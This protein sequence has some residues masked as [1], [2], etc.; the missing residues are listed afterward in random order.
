MTSNSSIPPITVDFF[1]IGAGKSGST[2][3]AQCLDEHPQ[4]TIARSKEPNFFV[5]K[6]SAF[7]G[8]S[9]REFMKDWAWYTDQY[10]HTR[11]GDRLGDFS[12]NLMHNVEDAPKLIHGLYP[13]AK[14]ITILR[15]PVQRTYSHYW[16]EKDHDR[17][18]G[19][20]NHFEDALDN[21]ELLFRSQYGTQLEAWRA[22]VPQE[23]FF[24]ILDFE[25]VKD[26][27]GVMRRLLRFLGVDDTF[28]PPSLVSRVN[29]SSRVSGTLGPLRKIAKMARS[30]GLGH[31]LDM[32]GRFGLQ[33]GIRNLL[34]RR[35]NYPPIKAETEA[36]LRREFTSDI[37]RL[38]KLFGVDLEV[39][40]G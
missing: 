3:L 24:L 19:V 35:R 29:E 23:S 17:I 1:C 4:I 9:N 25:M 13:S 38:E 11:P 22:Q 27:G 16:H 32:T 28:L 18:H 33:D 20:P 12:V 15:D 40:K 30:V 8:E 37:V 10:A 5:R 26:V 6:L 21:K 14:L 36:W 7:G 39:W 2:W 31:L 34:V